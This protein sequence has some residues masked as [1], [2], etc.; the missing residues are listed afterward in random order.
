[1]CL[2]PAVP[3]LWGREAGCW[4]WTAG[5]RPGSWFSERRTASPAHLLV[6]M[7]DCC[8]RK[9]NGALP[10][11]TVIPGSGLGHFAPCNFRVSRPVELVI[12]QHQI[13]DITSFQRQFHLLLGFYSTRCFNLPPSVYN[14][15][16]DCRGGQQEYT[17]HEEVLGR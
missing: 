10:H 3:K 2:I 6:G 17:E 4:T 16:Q 11:P 1:M 5:V 14:E 8:L 12:S 7:G 15:L 9:Q 13:Q